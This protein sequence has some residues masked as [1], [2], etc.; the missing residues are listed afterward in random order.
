MPLSIAEAIVAAFVTITGADA[1]EGWDMKIPAA[2]PADVLTLADPSDPVAQSHLWEA[3]YPSIPHNAIINTCILESGC[4]RIKP[5]SRY[6][7]EGTAIHKLDRHAGESAYRGTFR[8]GF[9]DTGCEF[10]PDPADVDLTDDPTTFYEAASTR[11]NFGMIAA[12]NTRRLGR[13]VPFEALDSPFF[14]AWSVAVKIDRICT[15]YERVRKKPCSMQAIRCAWAQAK[16]GSK[17]CGRVIRKMHKVLKRSRMR[18]R[19]DESYHP[20]LA[21]FRR[22]RDVQRITAATTTDV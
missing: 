3:I 10:W 15:K 20:T 11:G 7:I 19:I 4:R 12:Y 17:H 8:R 22:A 9:L 14:G 6:Y 18:K 5:T 2:V 21:D 1:F 13:C 16:W